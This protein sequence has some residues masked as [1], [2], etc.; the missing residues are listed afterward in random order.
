[1]LRVRDRSQAIGSLAGV[2]MARHTTVAADTTPPYSTVF[3]HVQRMDGGAGTHESEVP[4]S[5]VFPVLKNLHF[6]CL[7]KE[8]FRAVARIGLSVRRPVAIYMVY[9]SVNF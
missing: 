1:M 7:R 9:A 6:F 4:V 5:N 8:L 2:V 3:Q